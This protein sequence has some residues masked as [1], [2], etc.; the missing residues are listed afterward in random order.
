[1]SWTFRFRF[2][3]ANEVILIDEFDQTFT[4]VLP[5]YAMPPSMI[6]NRSMVLQSDASTFTMSIAK[7]K[8]KILGAHKADGRAKDQAALMKRWAKW[9]PDVNVTMSAHD[10]PSVMMDDRGKRRHVEAAK[11]GVCEFPRSASCLRVG[12]AGEF[13]GAVA[14]G[15]GHFHWSRSDTTGAGRNRRGRGVGSSP[16]ASDLRRLIPLLSLTQAL[17]IPARLSTKLA[18]TTSLRRS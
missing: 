16:F 14:D 10:G 5:F 8:V 6:H 11:K 12:E 3:Q 18:P 1:M 9:V 7:G 17:G 2:A 15:A 4:D 13:G